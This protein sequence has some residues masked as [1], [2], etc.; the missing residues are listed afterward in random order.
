M[1][2]NLEQINSLWRLDKSAINWNQTLWGGCICTEAKS[3]DTPKL[4]W[5]FQ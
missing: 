2:N 5:I 3:K 4:T 1:S